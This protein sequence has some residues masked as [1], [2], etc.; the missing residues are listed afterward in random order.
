LAAHTATG[1]GQLAAGIKLNDLI[2]M[3]KDWLL[4]SAAALLRVAGYFV[5]QLAVEAAERYCAAARARFATQSAGEKM[6]EHR[7]AQ[8]RRG[9]RH[10][11]AAS[12][13][14]DIEMRVALCFDGRCELVEKAIF[15]PARAPAR[16]DA[17]TIEE[18][19]LVAILESRV[20]GDGVE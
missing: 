8:L 7:A 11:A 15:Q 16:P 9:P 2:E 19:Q 3:E 1:S 10:L 13:G 12:R 14:D 6:S 18:Q 17:L 4:Q 20:V 5:R